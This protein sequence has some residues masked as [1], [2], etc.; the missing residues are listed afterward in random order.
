M[1]PT[2]V[3]E[4]HEVRE[5]AYREGQ[6]EKERDQMAIQKDHHAV[7]LRKGIYSGVRR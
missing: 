3:T 6:R 4:T 5:S 1:A 2:S 7:G